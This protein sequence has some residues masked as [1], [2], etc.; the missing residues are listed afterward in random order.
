MDW[1]GTW[2]SST[3][4]LVDDVV[5][6][7]GSSYISIQETSGTEN[8]SDTAYWQIVAQ[9]GSDGSG[10]SGSGSG[11]ASGGGDI[12]YA[13]V[14]LSSAQVAGNVGFLGM[15]AACQSSFGSTARIATT[16]DVYKTTGSSTANGIGWV[17]G[18]AHPGAANVDNITG[19][20]NGSSTSNGL[21][22]QGWSDT[23]STGLA[24]S[25]QTMQLRT[26]ACGNTGP[27]T[28]AVPD[29]TEENYVFAGF[30]TGS[31]SGAS[32]Y[33]GMNSACKASFGTDARIANSQE[34]IESTSVPAQSGTA[35]L[36]GI[37]HPKDAYIDNSTGYAIASTST[38]SCKGWSSS[39]GNQF[40]L[41]VNGSNFSISS[42][43]CW[44]NSPVA[45][46]IPE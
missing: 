46:S 34:L 11:S 2:A 20:I 32:G 25:T 23:S 15:N 21:S 40:G 8:P 38:L 36:Q 45:C 27:V 28:C 19:F 41:S 6:Y 9:Q 33:H 30:S 44:T 24:I 1:Q 5:E 39:D 12:Q 3:V 7:N 35:W 22:C 42:Q 16:E 31:A 13:V 17:R 18:I 4:Y 37:P 14:G 10:S 43:F 26:S 29:G